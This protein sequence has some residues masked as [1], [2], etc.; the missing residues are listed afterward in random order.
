MTMDNQEVELV[1]QNDPEKQQE[2]TDREKILDQMQKYAEED[3]K[4]SDLIILLD[5]VQ[6]K[7]FKGAAHA[8]DGT[9]YFCDAEIHEVIR[10]LPE[11]IVVPK[12]ALQDM[13]RG[14][15]Q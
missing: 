14:L 4:Y 6:H 5:P 3:Y 15:I 12:W 7:H 13:L 10:T 1:I 11:P 2:K 9:E 8:P